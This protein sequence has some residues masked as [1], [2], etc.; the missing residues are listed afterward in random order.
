M[1]VFIATLVLFVL[2]ALA[3]LLGFKSGVDASLD[4]VIKVMQEVDK[5]LEKGELK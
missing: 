3:Y 1:K 2:L 4:I 5:R